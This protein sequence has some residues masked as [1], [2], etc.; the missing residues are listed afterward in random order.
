MQ[1]LPRQTCKLFSY[2]S[3]LLPE[4]LLKTLFYATI[5]TCGN[6]LIS[7]RYCGINKHYK[8]RSVRCICICMCC[9]CSRWAPALLYVDFILAALWAV[10]C[11]DRS[12]TVGRTDGRGLEC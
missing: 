7:Q 4:R 1:V 5:T 9:D 11:E 2:G 8:L 3:I 6:S 12:P 10:A